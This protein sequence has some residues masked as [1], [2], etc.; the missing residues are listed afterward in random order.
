M[1]LSNR[2]IVSR[3]R[4]IKAEKEFDIYREVV[5]FRSNPDRIYWM[6]LGHVTLSTAQKCKTPKPPAHYKIFLVNSLSGS[7]QS[8][9]DLNYHTT[10][11]IYLPGQKKIGGARAW[12]FDPDAE[13][14]AP[15]KMAIQFVRILGCRRWTL[16][17]GDMKQ[18]ERKCAEKCFDWIAGV[19]LDALK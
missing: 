18:S 4:R 5:C 14:S 15:P 1:V 2:Q 6:T 3:L 16:I 19:K 7:G 10:V 13:A 17:C 8:S 11:V 9:K 12:V